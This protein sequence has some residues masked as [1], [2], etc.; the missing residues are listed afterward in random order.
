MS[1]QG[2]V[3]T[4]HSFYSRAV[5]TAH[6][7]AF[8]G[9]FQPAHSWLAAQIQSGAPRPYLFDIGCGDGSF[10]EAMGNMG[11]FGEGIDISAAFVAMAKK[12]ALIVRQESAS[13]AELPAATT[14]ITA[15]G[16][17]LAYAPAALAPVMLRA[18]RALPSGG[19]MIFDLPSPDTPERESEAKGDGWTMQTRTWIEGET[20]TRDIDMDF[21]GMRVQEWHKQHLFRPDDVRGIAQGFAMECE[22]L[23]SYGP[24]PLLPGRFAVLARKP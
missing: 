2:A 21:Q 18:S 14:A 9:T 16:E 11:I 8:A 12:R 17:V 5:A 10:L 1:G 24:C 7:E 22:I 3:T 20:L 13:Q 23:T 15:L 19:V 4:R 6:A